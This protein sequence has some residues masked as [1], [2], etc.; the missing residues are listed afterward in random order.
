MVPRAGDFRAILAGLRVALWLQSSM[1]T[2]RTMIPPN[3]P[4]GIALATAL[5]ALCPGAVAMAQVGNGGPSAEAFQILYYTVDYDSEGNA[6]RG[7]LMTETDLDGTFVNRARCECGQEIWARIVLQPGNYPNEQVRTFVGNRCD[8]AQTVVNPQLRPCVKLYESIP[9][10]YRNGVDLLF[11][12]VWLARGIDGTVQSVNDATAFGDCSFGRGDAGIWICVESNG[13]PDCQAEEFII[14]GNQNENTPGEAKALS[15]DFDTPFTLP[16]NVRVESGD[17]AVITRWTNETPD[18][19]GGFRVLCAD[20]SGNPLPGKGFSLRSITDVNLGTTYFT[21]ENLCP[22]GPFTEVAMISVDPGDLPPDPIDPDPDPDPEGDPDDRDSAAGFDA[23]PDEPAAFMTTGGIDDS[24]APGTGDT[25]TS[26][27]T[28]D[29]DTD[30]DTDIDTDTEGEDE[31]G[32]STEAVAAL[33]TLDWAYVCSDHLPYN[34]NSTRVTGLENGRPYHFVLVAYD[35]SGNPVAASDVLTA[36]P[37][38]TIDLWEQC[39]LAGEVCGDGGYCA[40]S[41]DDVRPM[42]ALGGLLGLLV[43]AGGVLHRRRRRR[44]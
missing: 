21:E 22:G 43:G 2:S 25:G 17:S 27:S 10:A 32:A 8:D 41:A 34:S 30:T 3:R 5:G 28:G 9:Q 18:P 26:G 23:W 7:R 19:G 38:E 29:T 11:H 44:K 42:G 20:A 4:T 14:K 40:C 13:Q 37:R 16:T 24:E 35:R 1:P 33:E 6:R 31:D 15:Y 36:T 12:P 39:E